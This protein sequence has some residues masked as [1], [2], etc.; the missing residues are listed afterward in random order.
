RTPPVLTCPKDQTLPNDKGK[1]TATVNWNFDFDDNSLKAGAP[2]ISKDKFTVVIMIND[3]K[4]SKKPKQLHIGT[5]R[6][7]YKVT[8]P[9]QNYKTC[10]FIVTVRDTEAP[11]CEYCPGNQKIEVTNDQ[12][13]R[14]IWKRPICSDNSGM[15]PS[16]TPSKR[17]G[18]EVKPP[19][20]YTIK[21]RVA[22]QA[23]PVANVYNDCS[24]TI[25][26]TVAGCKPFRPPKNGASKCFEWQHQ[27]ICTV[28]CQSSFDFTFN[29]A[30]I[31]M[32][33]KGRWSTYGHP[34]IPYENKLP[35]PDCSKRANPSFVKLIA[36]PAYF[37]HGDC[38]D[39]N[40]QAKLKQDFITNLYPPNSPPFFCMMNPNCNAQKVVVH[41]DVLDASS[42]RKRR[43]RTRQVN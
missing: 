12:P 26:V 23:K 42:R 43:A 33:D 25:K 16:I 36:N 31:Y 37:Y 10:S 29:P 40:V 18:F 20:L 6:V 19:A 2:G 30:Q 15:P 21:Y 22:D 24:F 3:V 9:D 11:T 35:W 38:N 17:N 32:C 1:N 8:D 5:H 7:L 28:A 41:C 27:L 34:M 4:F 13:Y 14:V 39:P